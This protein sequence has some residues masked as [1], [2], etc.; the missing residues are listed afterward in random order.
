VQTLENLNI[1]SELHLIVHIEP[2]NIVSP[3]PT[4]PS[5]ILVGAEYNSCCSVEHM[6]QLVSHLLRHANQQTS[7]VVNPAGDEW[8]DVL[9]M[10]SLSQLAVVHCSMTETHC[11]MLCMADCAGYAASG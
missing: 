9:S 2:V 11:N 5:I 3:E 8:N 10:S 4:Q 6:L 1:H 7:T